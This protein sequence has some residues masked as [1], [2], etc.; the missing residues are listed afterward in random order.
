M[1]RKWLSLKRVGLALCGGAVRAL[2]HI[3]VLKVF[4]RENIKIHT[5]CGASMGAII[6]GLYACGV[7][8]EDMEAAVDEISVIRQLNLDLGRKSILGD[9]IYGCLV[10]VLEKQACVQEIEHLAIP[11]KAVSVDLITGK[12]VIHD[13]GSLLNALKASSAIPGILQ[14][15]KCG[16]RVLVDGGVLNNVPVDLVDRDIVDVAIAVD[17]NQITNEEEPRN[18]PELLFRTFNVMMTASR[19]RSLSYAD[20]IIQPDVREI[21]ALDIRKIK[22]A[23]QA[24]ERAAEG[25]LKEILELIV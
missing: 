2:A 1:R 18:I 24:G 3:G 16:N 13:Q 21:F 19:T 15:V 7:K 12:Q 25:Q 17:V 8:T 6:G 9:K 10:N 23:I 20:M 11:F 22:S 5:I 4:N 14:P